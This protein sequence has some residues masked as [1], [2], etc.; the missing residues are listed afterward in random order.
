MELLQQLVLRMLLEAIDIVVGTNT[1]GRAGIQLV[2][3]ILDPEHVKTQLLLDGATL[4]LLL[5]TVILAIFGI[6]LR[7]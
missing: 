3:A 7:R 6:G 1:D 4:N 5:L 2:Q